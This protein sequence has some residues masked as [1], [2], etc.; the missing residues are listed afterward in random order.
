MNEVK[1]NIENLENLFKKLISLF[2]D[3]YSFLLKEKD[4][5]II[6][7][8]KSL[9]DITIEKEKILNQ[10]S[11]VKMQFKNNIA[12]IKEY[13]GYKAFDY[14]PITRIINIIDEPNKKNLNDCYNELQ[15][16]M[17]DI[18][19]ISIINRKLINDGI[20]FL[21]YFINYLRDSECGVEVYN[22]K[23]DKHKATK[24]LSF[25]DIQL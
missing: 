13:Y 19:N 4:S 1:S 7:D 10:I 8:L 15:K 17:A 12:K 3:L 24:E 21:N 25:L 14:V 11:D 23:G 18:K 20:N 22:L 6:E 9:I 16:I 2:K 5:I